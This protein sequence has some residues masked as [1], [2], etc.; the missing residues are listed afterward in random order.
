[1]ECV[2]SKDT[3]PQAFSFKPYRVNKRDLFIYLFDCK[4]TGLHHGNKRRITNIC[5]VCFQGIM[6][7]SFVIDSACVGY[8]DPIK[9]H[10]PVGFIVVDKSNA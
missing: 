5:N 4:L 9:G 1:M 3:A 10:V 7:P 6:K 2:W 8:K